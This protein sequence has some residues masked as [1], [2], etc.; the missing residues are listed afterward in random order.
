MN[1]ESVSAFID[2]GGYGVYVWGSFAVTFELM[3]WELLTLRQ[4]RRKALR[5]ARI[6]RTQEGNRGESHEIAS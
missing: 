5:N 4:R 2:M 3:A 6:A 1:W